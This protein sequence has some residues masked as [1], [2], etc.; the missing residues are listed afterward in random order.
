MSP[1]VNLYYATATE[2]ERHHINTNEMTT[3]SNGILII[4]K[5]E[6]IQVM[7]I[8]KEDSYSSSYYSA[9][10]MIRMSMDGGVGYR[11]Q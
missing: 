6:M 3:S 2:A 11:R 5:C 8:Q 7:L 1:N 10:D 9:Q 4:V